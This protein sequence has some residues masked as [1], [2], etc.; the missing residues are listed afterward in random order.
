MARMSLWVF[1][2]SLLLVFQMIQSEEDDVKLALIKFYN[3]LSG[4]SGNPNLGWDMNTDPCTNWTG[5]KCNSKLTAVKK[6]LLDNMLLSGTLDADSLCAAESLTVLSLNNNIITGDIPQ[7]MESCTQLTHIFLSGNKLSGNLPGS[8]SSLNNLKRFDISHNNVSGVLPDFSRISGLISFLAQNNSLTGEIPQFDFMNLQEFN[9]SFNNLTGPIPDLKGRFSLDSVMGNPGLCGSPLPNKCPPSKNKSKITVE[10]VLTYSG[11]MIL[12]LVIL[13]FIVFKLVSNKKPKNEKIHDVAKM[14]SGI[15]SSSKNQ[16]K[17]TSSDYKSD[18]IR[19][20]YSI[21]SETGMVSSSLV[22]LTSPIVK[23]LKFDDLLKAPAELLGRGRHGSLYK[24]IFEDGMTLA[25]KRIKDWS[26]SSEE[27]KSRMQRIDQAKHPNVMDLVA[28]YCSKQEKLVVYNYQQNGSLFKLLH[29]NEN[30]RRFDWGSR[31]SVAA[32]IA[33]T[34]AF[35]HEKLYADGIPHG[36]L[37][38]S[39]IVFNK[40]MDPCISEYGLMIV[41]H[42]DY[43]STSSVQGGSFKSANQSRDGMDSTF[44]VDIYGYGVLLLE[45]LTGKQVQ[46][47]GVDLARWVNSVVREEWTAEVFDKILIKEGSSEERMLH[48][49]QVALKCIDPAQESTRPTMKEV[50]EM[51]NIIKEDEEERSIDIY[52]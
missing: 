20:E 35:M 31:L 45:L 34:L 16:S 40:N 23:G 49:L 6:I 44:E 14:E 43:S 4:G 39:N 9:V 13:I 5:V 52:E 46:N 30:V 15:D 10:K 36:N 33:E 12:G 2:F 3:Q 25:V 19:S 47:N 32:T 22:V 21:T 42:Q 28:F 18:V 11:Y 26:I 27:F 7:G 50:A 29:E 24:V 38:S 8:L 41:E 51:M 37:K 48:L 1:V 17:V